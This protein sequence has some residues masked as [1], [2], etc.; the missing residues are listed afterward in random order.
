[1]RTQPPTRT[2]DRRIAKVAQGQYGLITRNQ[3]RREG[4]SDD[5]VSR[6]L[7]RG[8]L[9]QVHRGVFTVGTP[10][11]LPGAREL[12]AVL[13][14]QP[15]AYASH[16]SAA[17]LLDLL[18]LPKNAA[19]AEVSVEGR[20]VRRKGIRV[21]RVARFGPG[22]VGE[23]DDIPVTSPART[24]LDL[25]GRLDDEALEQLV[26]EAHP[27]DRTITAQL[28]DLLTPHRHRHGIA[29]LRA[30]LER[31]EEP[32][33]TRSR[34]E[35]RLLTLIRQRGLPEPR[36]N[37]VVHGL[38]V[39]LYR[40]AHRLVVEFDSFT[41]HSSR[42]AFETDRY[43]DQRL[44]AGGIVVVRVTWLQLTRTPEAVV[45]RIAQALSRRSA[46]APG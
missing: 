46:H 3:L 5:S 4:L 33:R 6:R 23:I 15:R 22:E 19:T 31:H 16:R 25:S 28:T 8:S 32:K 18:S 17:H 12:A 45:E 42:R 20:D 35:R 34:W 39:D 38:E 27:Q 30:L 21:H 11:L 13:A 9:H 29:P 40:P 36:T 2:V 37:A 41:F 10:L 24:I 43:R 1:M 26:A 44:A 14:C 7:R